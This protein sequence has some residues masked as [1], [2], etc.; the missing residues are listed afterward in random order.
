MY[1]TLKTKDIHL[2]YIDNSY[3]VYY[4]K[5]SFK[6]SG[7]QIN[8]LIKNDKSFELSADEHLKC[9][10]SEALNAES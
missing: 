1:F 5:K 4:G 8:N 9:S 7:Y 2:E 3:I 6:V 10:A